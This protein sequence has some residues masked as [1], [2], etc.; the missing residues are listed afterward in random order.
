MNLIELMR[1]WVYEYEA[2]LRI[3][4]IFAGF[5]LCMA[6]GISILKVLFL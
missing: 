4:G 6:F 5:M 1:E 2:Q 3:F